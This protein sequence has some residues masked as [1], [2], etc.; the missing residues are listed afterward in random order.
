MNLDVLADVG[1]DLDEHFHVCVD[2]DVDVDG[3]AN[4]HGHGHGLRHTMLRRANRW[5][6]PP[7]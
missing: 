5:R 7:H 1:A 2:A 4:R 6:S 3:H